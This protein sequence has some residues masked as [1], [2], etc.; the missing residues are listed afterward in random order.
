MAKVY[1]IPN[2]PANLAPIFP[3]IDFS[4]VAEY[5]VELIDSESAVVATSTMNQICGCSDD[6]DCVRIHFL[7][8]LGAI[9]S[10]NFKIQTKENDPKSDAFEKPTSYPLDKTA[11]AKGR[12]NVRSGHNY[13]AITLDY[14]ESQMDWIDELMDSPLAWIEG[15]AVQG[16]PVTF[17][18]IV[19]KDRKSEVIKK[20]DRYMYETT[21]EFIKSHDKFII[22]N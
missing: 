14:P 17:I 11:H 20:E 6:E 22:R 13:T 15:P 9:D 16:Q 19:I 1:Y 10:I 5:F 12:F 21:I 4:N 18:P 7:N 2:G 3:T 8:Y